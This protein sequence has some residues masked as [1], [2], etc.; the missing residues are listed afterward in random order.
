ME[1]ASKAVSPEAFA[2]IPS[3]R[4][5]VLRIYVTTLHEATRVAHL[6]DVEAGAVLNWSI[7]SPAPDVTHTGLPVMV[8]LGASATPTSIELS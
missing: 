2:C 6:P 8:S 7:V 4:C 5:E 3:L 1:Q